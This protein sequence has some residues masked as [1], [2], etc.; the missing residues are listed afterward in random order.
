M[1]KL[2]DHYQMVDI[3]TVYKKVFEVSMTINFGSYVIIP[4][5]KINNRGSLNYN[6]ICF[7]FN[8]EKALAIIVSFPLRVRSLVSK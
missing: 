5:T 1:K 2:Y 6:L 3:R 4:T 8:F 7:C